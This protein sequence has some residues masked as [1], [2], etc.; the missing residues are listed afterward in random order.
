MLAETVKERYR[1]VLD[2]LPDRVQTEMHRL[3]RSRRGGASSL[4][5]LRLRVG[6]V[7]TALFDGE[8]VTLLSSPTQSEMEELLSRACD[9]ALYAHR[10]SICSGYVTVGAGVRIGVAGTARYDSSSV[11]GISDV[12]YAL[13]RF[14]GDRCHF[15]EELFRA[16]EEAHGGMLIYS[17]PGVGK[18]TAL[19]HLARSIGRAPN[20]RQVCIVD[21]RFEFCED[22]FLDSEVDILKGYKRR[23]GLEI[24]TRTMSPEVVI[25]DEIGGDDASGISEVVRCGIPLIASAHAG[26]YDELMSKPSLEPLLRCGAFETFVGICRRDGG[27]ALTVNR[28]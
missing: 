2:M 8:C 1:E 17:P 7:C 11:V 12:R 25:I 9:G 23:A 28:G 13:I 14:P 6:G 24:A 15:G 10:D 4:R 19:R 16:W 22:D 18:T 3:M 21:E 20:A 27:Y 5:E 26:S